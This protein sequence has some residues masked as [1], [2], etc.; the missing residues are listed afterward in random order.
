MKSW[1]TVVLTF[2]PLLLVFSLTHS[3]AAEA[4][5]CTM[6]DGES[7]AD[8]DI[9]L[10]NVQSCVTG[11]LAQGTMLP[12]HHIADKKGYCCKTDGNPSCRGGAAGSTNPKTKNKWW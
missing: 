9:P 7:Y 12:C 4:A 2:V 1:K 6:T 10:E 11:S 3:F 8:C 5:Q